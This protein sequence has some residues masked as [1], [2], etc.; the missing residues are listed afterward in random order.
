MKICYVCENESFTL[1][2]GSVRDNSKLD[3]LE[4]T[5]CGL[6]FLS[7]HTHIKETHYENSGMHGGEVISE[8]EWLKE[9]EKD[10]ER[11]FRFLKSKLLNKRLLDFGCGVGGFLLKSKS[12]TNQSEGVE[13]ELRL[14]PY[15]SKFDLKVW[16]N[17]DE[18]LESKQA[19]D[20]ITAF[21]V[22][23]H[24]KDPITVI[25]SLIQLLNPNGEL[26]IEVPSSNDALLTLY[27]SDEF[28]HFTYW[29]QHL[30]LFNNETFK[31]LI[32]KSKLRLNWLK[33]I[34]RYPLSNHLYW[35]SKGQPG[36]HNVW[37]FLDNETIGREYESQL[38]S[39]GLCDTIIASVSV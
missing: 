17:L 8:T 20:I 28:S 25:R 22:I 2:P 26:I 38:A 1:R 13:L 18:V 6:V 9:N 30:F 36:G 14:Q 19:Y 34:Q 29:S 21:H 7:E 23:E 31:R 16:K 12:I 4:C 27:K 15:Y 5:N 24:L 37:S 3:I 39:I 35:L 11:R 33:Q 32:Q 10:D